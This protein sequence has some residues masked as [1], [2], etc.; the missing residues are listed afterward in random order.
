MKCFVINLDRRQDRLERFTKTFGKYFEIIKESAVDNKDLIITPALK[1]RINE[2]NFKYIPH[3]VK[4]ITACCLSHINVW[5]KISKMNESYVF[6]FEDD[7]TFINEMVETNFNI[8]FDSLVFPKDFGI[9]WMQGNIQDKPGTQTQLPFTIKKFTDDNTAESYIITPSFAK[10]LVYEIEN[11]LG[12]VDRHMSDYTRKV[13]NVSFKVF[14][15]F[16]CQ[17][18]R[19]DTDIQI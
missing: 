7:C 16:F 18:D 15:P 17:F 11:N 4:N 12:A 3:K 1:A 8:Y 5:K 13:H 19:R 10:E 6:V 9:I 14:P 2:W